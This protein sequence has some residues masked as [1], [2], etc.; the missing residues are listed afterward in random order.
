MFARPRSPAGH[1]DGQEFQPKDVVLCAGASLPLTVPSPLIVTIWDQVSEGINAR[2][3]AEIGGLVLGR[4]TPTGIRAEAVAPI[5]IEHRFGPAFRLSPPDL[6]G[7]QSLVSSLQKDPSQKVV[8]LYR[9]RTRND[10]LSEESES[11]LLSV[12][13]QAHE[14]FE[15]DFHYFIAFT[16]LSQ[17]AMTASTS[18]RE[19][20]GWEE[21]QHVRLLR[22]ASS[23]ARPSDPAAPSKD[24]LRIK[25]SFER[26]PRTAEEPRR[27]EAGA[28]PSTDR[29]PAPGPVP[30]PLEELRPAN[31]P[32]G[33]TPSPLPAA[34]PELQ[35]QEIG[36]PGEISEMQAPY[37]RDA[38]AGRKQLWYAGGAILLAALALTAYVKSRPATTHRLAVQDTTAIPARA[39]AIPPTIG[40]TA[41]RD[42]SL[43]KLN[44][45][46][47]AVDALHPTAAMLSIRDAA[48]VQEFGLTPAD[49]SKGSIVYEPQSGDLVFTMNLVLPSGQLAEEHVRV[50]AGSPGEPVVTQPSAKIAVHDQPATAPPAAEPAPKPSD[51]PS[52]APAIADVPAPP[53]LTTA[54]SQPLSGVLPLAPAPPKPLPAPS[55]PKAAVPA[56]SSPVTQLAQ[57]LVGSWKATFSQSPIPTESATLSVTIFG[58]DASGWFLGN[59][60]IPKNGPP[61]KPPVKLEFRG[62]VTKEREPDGAWLFP[63]TTGAGWTG[64]IKLRPQGDALDVTWKA[65][66]EDGK[67]YTFEHVMVHAAAK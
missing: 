39:A 41:T 17:S 29:F 37:G 27:R 9:S 20:E 25:L 7:L 40:F 8:G 2:G 32:L 19:A 4:T 44:W 64:T 10:S 59:Y 55:V 60:K 5:S 18:F 6:L 22:N 67:T 42:G 35:P 48:K 14:S 11:S 49:L 34:V 65:S 31:P 58:G 30:P 45:D 24:R 43:W 56:D 16:P 57:H 46:H 36:E 53:V 23:S 52:A 15:S 50:L 21:W 13:E 62:S 1:P 61:L 66:L 51:E 28:A 33:E 47:T 26:P 3:G 63:V 12:L 38:D 54:P